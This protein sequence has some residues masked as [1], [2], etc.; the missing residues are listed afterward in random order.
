[1]VPRPW[2]ES[3]RLSALRS[4]KIL[5]T[6]PEAH[7]DA[8]CR[9][10]QALFGVP[11][12]L[13]PLVEENDL[14]FKAKCG[15]TS[16]GAPRDIAFCN[17]TILSDDVLIVEDTSRDARFRDNPLVTGELGVRFYAGAP[18]ALTSGLR[19]GTLCII[20]TAPRTFSA[21]QVSQLR[22]LAEVV[23]AHLREYEARAARDQA[24]RQAREAA[25]LLKASLEAMDQGLMMVDAAG[26]VRV[27]NGR[28]I[29]MLDLPAEM[30]LAQPTFEQV[31]QH[32]LGQG[33]FAKAPETMRAWVANSGLERTRHAYERERP[34]GAVLEI[35]TVPLPDGGAVRTYTDI[36]ARKQAEIQIARSEARYR[37]LADGLPQMVWVM[38][39]GDGE[40]VYRNAR[41]LD[42]YGEIG[43]SRAARIA[44]NHPDD[45]ARVEREWVRC[46]AE[47]CPFEAEV[48]L[49]RHDGVHR[50]HKL[51]M[52]PI[53]R[54]GEI[55][56]FLGTA[57]DIEDIVTA[58]EALRSTTDRLRLAQEAAGAGLFEWN[59]LDGSAVLSPESLRLFNLPEDR[60][61][62]VTEAE[63]SAAMHPDDL[64]T[65]AAET[66]R[67]I[68]TR[69]TLR[70]EFRIPLPDGTDRWVIGMGRVV[71]N[72]E[73]HAV[74]V[75]GISLDQT[76][77]K[78]A[79]QA[80]RAKEAAL[81]ESEERLALALDS[82][83][84]GLWDCDLVTGTS[85]ISDQWLLMLGYE[86][87]ELDPGPQTWLRLLH[88][89]DKDMVLSLIQDHVEGRTASYECEHRMRRKDGGWTWILERGKVVARAPDGRPL[90][91]V[92][93]HIDV[94]AR[95]VAEARIAHMARHDALTDLP[96]RA[97]FRERLEQRLAEVRRYGGQC[98]LICADLDQFKAVND[99]L[100]HLAGDALLR[101]IARRLR[102]VLRVEDTVA[103]LGGD[104]FA[105][106]LGGT[107]RPE[108]VAELADR[109]IAA[110]R[111]PV[112]LGDQQVGVGVSLGI[113]LGPEQGED[114][115]TLFKRADRALYRA[116]EDGRNIYRFFEPAMDTAAEERRRLELDLHLALRRGEFVLHYQPIVAIGTSEV[117]GVEALVRWQ[118]PTRGLL[119]PGQFIATAEE[120]GLIVPLGEWVLRAATQ[121]AQRLPDRV[122]VAVNISPVQ[123]QHAS[124]GQTVRSALAASGL[125]PSRLELEI[126]ESVLMRDSG[127]VR[128]VLSGLRN[129]GVG[130]ALDDFGTGY[131]SLSYL[132]DL[133]FDKLKIDRSFV[134]AITDPGT[135]AIV[136]AIVGLGH[137]LGMSVTAEGVETVE[138][139]ALVR[140]EGCTQVQGYLISRPAPLDEIM[141]MLSL[142]APNAQAPPGALPARRQART[143]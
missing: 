9:I 10:A 127:L 90:R 130:I 132:R 78:R 64:P 16:D 101:E 115:D 122:R 54:E 38:R 34:N 113:A 53:R 98:A 12:A 141:P 117:V 66:Q 74:R 107:M 129:L 42:Y 32:Q 61:E 120:T 73:G 15:L 19:L 33:E 85:W 24:E 106:L 50:W 48:R 31:R 88:P 29:D 56:E 96:N 40:A 128:D 62:P 125:S 49:R 87:G 116:K 27:C 37:A 52:I 28:V 14:W 44:R 58:R 63:W 83:S 72:E 23:S 103:R 82:G 3:E 111:E 86:P 51:V 92:G 133:P 36:T 114:G 91:M 81:R 45:A 21:E 94:T 18:L 119:G 70:I 67:A 22:D 57:L 43:T 77:R 131:S 5:N 20:D 105:I 137:G 79:E 126:T 110:V 30:M 140:G 99:S 65:L 123:V 112:W 135:A 80:L 75:V 142:G 109:L 60:T 4:L 134:A 1:M 25:A 89:D 17:Y 13:I 104:E 6:P 124:L 46:R 41:F 139:L 97:L 69:S 35:R 102:S 7:F 93:T 84:D 8:I 118:H 136:R 2:S 55:V 71:W 11:I 138:Q 121:D 76:D 100:G 47:D 108:A 68:A 26:V 39:P 59:L 143:A 95:K